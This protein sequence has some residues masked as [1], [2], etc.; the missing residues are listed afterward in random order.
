[1][2]LGGKVVSMS[3]SI[4]EITDLVK[5]YPVRQD[6]GKKKKQFVRAVDRV[7]LT[8][9][10]GEVLGLVGESGCGKTT[11][12]NTVLNLTA[13]TSGRV[14]FEGMDIFGLN[15]QTMRTVRRNIQIVFQDP[16]W[17][18]N[19]RMLVKDIIGEPLYV[20]LHLRGEALIEQVNDLLV[21]VGLPK[22]GAFKYAHEFSGGERQRIAIARAL[23][24]MPK[25]IVLDEPTSSI[26]IVSQIQILELLERLKAKLELTYIVIS[27]DMSVISYMSDRI[28]VMYLGKIVELGTREEI[29]E[30]PRHPYTQALLSAVPSIEIDDVSK[31]TVLEGSV[32]SSIDPPPG[33]RFHTRCPHVMPQCM[34]IEPELV[35]FPDGR[36]V[37]CHLV[38]EMC[39]N[40]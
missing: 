10:K 27:H 38:S 25:L 23:A 37:A 7:N 4:L 6:I 11:L 39:S 12:V 34:E 40:T 20:Q 26:D 30:D 35:S 32:P 14:L 29:F 36:E 8:M 9:N 2:Q 3:D 15:K 5:Y 31:L 28:A 1:M 22:E 13:P 24:L 16:F 19:P 18:L 17:S 21:M 33:C